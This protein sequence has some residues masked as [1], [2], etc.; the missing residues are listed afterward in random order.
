MLRLQQYRFPLQCSTSLRD[1]FICVLDRL[2]P[3]FSLTMRLDF[4]NHVT[5]PSILNSES[6]PGN[7]S[8]S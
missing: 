3:A 8:V 7:R 6:Y 1:R 4:T 2:R 5:D